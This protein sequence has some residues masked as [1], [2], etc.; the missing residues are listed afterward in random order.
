MSRDE[1]TV[2]E[3]ALESDQPTPGLLATARALVGGRRF[4]ARVL[5]RSAVVGILPALYALDKGGSAA[6][7]PTLLAVA[8]L[9]AVMAFAEGLLLARPR[10]PSFLKAGVGLILVAWI[11]LCAG[12]VEYCYAS[13][14]LAT[15]DVNAGIA[16][17]TTL[18]TSLGDLGLRSSAMIVTLF[19]H[20]AG[21]AGLA[22]ALRV[23]DKEGGG[24]E[25]ALLV[26]GHALV[27]A[28][29]SSVPLQG[30][31]LLVSL[32]CPLIATVGFTALLCA[33]YEGAE[34]AVTLADPRHLARER[35][36]QARREKFPGTNPKPSQRD[37]G[38][39]KR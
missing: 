3:T 33:A 31:N 14:V 4:W 30:G 37:D 23:T 22:S 32:I 11:S 7:A 6:A 5:M 9:M 19:F 27:F 1:T 29:L 13:A 2:D 35:L 39:N 26:S 21:A 24:V 12:L 8:G 34:R 38:T 15:G 28:L 20:L 18:A 25:A 17:L 36:R 10:R 16:A